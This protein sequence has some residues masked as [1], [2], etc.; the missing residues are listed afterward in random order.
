MPKNIGFGNDLVVVYRHQRHGV[1]NC[2][3]QLAGE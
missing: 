2:S 1:E 3:Y